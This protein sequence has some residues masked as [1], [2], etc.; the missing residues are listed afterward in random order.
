[1]AIA[2]YYDLIAS[3]NINY[4]LMDFTK[5]CI[6]KGYNEQ[7][8]FLSPVD[9]VWSTIKGQLD[10][11]YADPF[12]FFGSGYVPFDYSFEHKI[13]KDSSEHLRIHFRNK[14]AFDRINCEF[15]YKNKQIRSAKIECIWYSELQGSMPYTNTNSYICT[16]DLL[17]ML[18]VSTSTLKEF[19]ERLKR[20]LPY[21]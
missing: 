6:K 5:K 14:S 1:M 2:Q 8:Y 13:L 7:E 3:K 9:T 19:E 12:V 16:T 10:S 17:G 20:I 21:L 4:L 18:K 11:S 15:I